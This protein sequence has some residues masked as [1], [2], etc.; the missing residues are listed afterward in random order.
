VID[1]QRRFGNGRLLPAGPLREPVA[2]L[3]NVDFI[4]CNGGSAAIGEIPM[5][6]EGDVAVSVAQPIQSRALAHFANQRV[7]AIAGIGN[8]QRF[9]DSLRAHSIEV[10]EH[11]FPDHY[12]LSL[13]DLEFDDGLPV[14]MTEK[15]AVKCAEFATPSC[16]CVPVRAELP[17][18]FLDSLVARLRD[19]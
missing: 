11:P 18:Q 7:H 9:F 19:V 1:G 5:H 6:L 16:W 3:E 17:P 10:I 4:I 8:P 12:A 15:D 13:K 14:L 2:R